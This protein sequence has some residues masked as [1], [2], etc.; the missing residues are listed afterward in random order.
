[1]DE[2]TPKKRGP[3]PKSSYL[4]PRERKEKAKK[5]ADEQVRNA[6]RRARRIK[7]DIDKLK[8]DITEEKE[9]KAGKVYE[10]EYVKSM[11]SPARQLAE[12][13]VLFQPNE[14]PQTDFLDRKSVV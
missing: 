11:V 3:K 2:K 1:M 9:T 6:T 14:G 5:K 7:K 8:E 10:D 13:N 12:D 4:T